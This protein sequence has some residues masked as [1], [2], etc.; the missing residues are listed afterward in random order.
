MIASKMWADLERMQPRPTLKVIRHMPK[1]HPYSQCTK[2]E[3]K[4]Y[5]IFEGI[6]NAKSDEKAGK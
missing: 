6:K 1:A 3:N 5:P 2:A 4:A